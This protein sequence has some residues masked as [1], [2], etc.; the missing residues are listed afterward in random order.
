MAAKASTNVPSTIH[1]IGGNQGTIGKTLFTSMLCH[2]YTSNNRK[3]VLF[4]TDTGKQNISAQYESRTDANFEGCTEIMMNYSDEGLKADL[5]YE[6]A[7]NQDSKQTAV[8]VIVDTPSDSH[9]KLLYWLHRN[10]LDQPE[11][12]KSEN[13]KIQLW[14]LSNGSPTSLELLKNTL[15]KAQA[16]TVVL[17]KNKGVDNEW[18]QD[19]PELAEFLQ[20]QTSIDLGVMP[21]GERESTFKKGVAYHNYQ[22]N[23]LSVNRL[24]AYLQ[25]QSKR[26]LELFPLSVGAT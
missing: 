13:L 16:L 8:D 10:G 23:K 14:F 11:F 22:G 20:N 17:V 1:L 3:F 7:T 6:A 12:L 9:A 19:K 24:N 18:N 25:E 5:V 15:P 4:N 2:L 26:I 21:R